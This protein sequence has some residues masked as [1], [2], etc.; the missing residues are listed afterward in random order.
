MEIAAEKQ[1][2]KHFFS[3]FF[4][5]IFVMFSDL[6]KRINKNKSAAKKTAPTV[7]SKD[8]PNKKNKNK[9][10]KKRLKIPNTLNKSNDFTRLSYW[11]TS[12]PEIRTN[13]IFC[14]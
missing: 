6:F 12:P 4:L 2:P 10:K 8:L 7:F 11:I 5:F 14:T 3:F 1:Q 9:T 13:Y